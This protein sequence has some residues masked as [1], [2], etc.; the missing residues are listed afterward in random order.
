MRRGVASAAPS[1]MM[2]YGL[3]ADRDQRRLHRRAPAARR[4]AAITPF[5]FPA[6]VPLWFLPFAGATATASS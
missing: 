1:L 4:R 6:M 2:G 3:G 5:N